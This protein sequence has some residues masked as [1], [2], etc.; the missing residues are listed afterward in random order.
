MLLEDTHILGICN[1]SF[2][3]LSQMVLQGDV[4]CDT[5]V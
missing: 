2:V 4:P 1:R 5:V 3:G